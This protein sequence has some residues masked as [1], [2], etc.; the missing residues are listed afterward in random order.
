MALHAGRWDVVR[1]L[2]ERKEQEW[3]RC[4]DRSII[5]CRETAAAW[6][7]SWQDALRVLR[8]QEYTGQV[9]RGYF[10]EGLSGAQ[11]I[12]DKDFHSALLALEQPQEELSWLNAADPAQ[13]WGKVIPHLEGRSF[14]NVPGTAVAI[15][16]G[17]PQAV[18][19]RQG[20]TLRTFGE[21]SLIHI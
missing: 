6:N 3:E 5:L 7:V 16:A 10:V 20:K 11:F 19:E 18:F 9:R 4:F 13:I 15:K 12:R 14:T 1:P 2:R 17:V 8:I 21:L